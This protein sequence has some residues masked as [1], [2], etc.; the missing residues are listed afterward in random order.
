[1]DSFTSKQY[2]MGRKKYNHFHIPGTG[3]TNDFVFALATMQF[4]EAD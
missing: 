1:M 3:H 4:E 2:V